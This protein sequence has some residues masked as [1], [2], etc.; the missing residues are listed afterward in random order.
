MTRARVAV[1][2]TLLAVSCIA[3]DAA[4][5]G[6]PASRFGVDAP[7]LARLGPYAVGVRSLVLRQAAQADVLAY[8]ATTHAAPLR[9]RVLG[10]ELW[11][12]ANPSPGALPTTYRGSFPSEPPAPPAQFTQA[13]IAVRDAPPAG[14]GFPLV[15]VSHGYSNDVAAFTWIT[16]NLASKGYVVAAIRH[17]DPPLTDRSKLPEVIL[18]RPLDVAYVAH[19]LQ[20]RLGDEHL[21]DPRRIALLGYSAGGYGV[22][23]VAG[24][25]LDPESP[26][27]MH[28]PG[29]LLT[30]YARGGA[31]A[32]SLAVDGLRAAVAIAPMGGG[33]SRP[34]AP[35]DSPRSQSPCCSSR[36]TPTAGFPTRLA[37]EP[38]TGKQCTRGGTS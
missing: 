6:E 1:R 32:P 18:R 20:R 14:R 8:D 16:E 12:P 35:M 27:V 19:A 3:A 4:T 2:I 28:M 36:A 33:H 34:S 29:G 22:L 10:I 26:A 7:E 13:G 11:Y 25:A 21:I 38:S 23:A 30:P 31:L 9:D 17:N 37:R 15:V 24:A 5:A